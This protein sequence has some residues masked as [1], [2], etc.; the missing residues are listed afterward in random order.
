MNKD[1]L[2]HFVQL[3][4]RTDAMLLMGVVCSL[5]CMVEWQGLMKVDLCIRNKVRKIYQ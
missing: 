1:D 3:G 5:N 4:K 2:L